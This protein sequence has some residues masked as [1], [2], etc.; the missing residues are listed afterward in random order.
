MPGKQDGPSHFTQYT[1]QGYTV[2]QLII[3]DDLFG[4]IGELKKIAKINCH[5]NKN[6]AILKYSKVQNCQINVLPNCHI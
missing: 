2:K 3:G 5:Q 4:E 1:L 6:I